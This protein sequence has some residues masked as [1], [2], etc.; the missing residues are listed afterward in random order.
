[1]PGAWQG[2]PGMEQDPWVPGAWQ[3]HRGMGEDPRVPGTWQGHRGMGQDPWVPRAWQGHRGMGQDPWV[4][5]AWQGHPGAGPRARRRAQMERAGARAGQRAER[6]G[7][8]ERRS[9]DVYY[10]SAASV[11]CHLFP[12]ASR[13]GGSS[14]TGLTRPHSCCHTWA[15][16]RAGTAPGRHPHGDRARC[17]MSPLPPGTVFRGVAGCL[18]PCHG[19]SCGKGSLG[20]GQPPVSAGSAPPQPPSLETSSLPVFL[21]LEQD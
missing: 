8:W 13:A 6:A 18:V 2:H 16:A 14:L 21:V 12:A 20:S 17:G 15:A 4:P 11:A 3:G 9:L 19:A 1:M 5:G 7:G 10:S